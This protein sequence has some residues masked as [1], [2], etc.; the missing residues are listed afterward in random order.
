MNTDPYR[1][2]ESENAAGSQDEVLRKA[3]AVSVALGFIAL[4]LA[5][6]YFVGFEL[7]GG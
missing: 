5:V 2:P 3:I 1:P 7:V 4:V 6:I